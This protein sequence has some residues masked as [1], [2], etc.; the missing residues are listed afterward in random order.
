MLPCSAV[1]RKDTISQQW[2]EYLTTQPV[3]EICWI[4]VREPS[5]IV[6]ARTFELRREHGF[7][8]LRVNCTECWRSKEF[9]LQC[10][11]DVFKVEQEQLHQPAIPI[12]FEYL[13]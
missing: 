7:Q 4:S 11:A 13:Q 8:V 9:L 2:I 1:L 12:S 3:A 6:V 10:V 5:P